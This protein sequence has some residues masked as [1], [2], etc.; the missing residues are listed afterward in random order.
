MA[1]IISIS[2]RDGKLSE[3]WHS[4]RSRGRKFTLIKP[5]KILINK[6]ILT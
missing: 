6:Y 3:M 4:K 2:L 5:L 1:I